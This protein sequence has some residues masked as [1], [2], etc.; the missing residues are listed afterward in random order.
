MKRKIPLLALGFMMSCLP[1]LAQTTTP[2]NEMSLPS[3]VKIPD[4]LMSGDINTIAGNFDGDSNN[5]TVLLGNRPLPVLKESS[6]HVVFKIPNDILGSQKLT[7]IENGRS[8]SY[9]CKVV[10]VELSVDKPHLVKGESATVTLK[11]VGMHN[12]KVP[13]SVT[14]QNLSP[15]NVR[16]QGGAEQMVM[17]Y[18]QDVDVNGTFTKSFKLKARQ[19]GGF[20]IST[21]LLSPP[22]AEWN[23]PNITNTNPYASFESEYE[24]NFEGTPVLS[25]NKT[26]ENNEEKEQSTVPE[27]E[28]QEERNKGREIP[29]DTPLDPRDP[30]DRNKPYSRPVPPG[31]D[32][33]ESEERKYWKDM[34]ALLEDA[35]EQDTIA[36]NYEGPIVP[37]IPGYPSMSTTTPWKTS[38]FFK[39]NVPCREDIYY[40]YQRYDYLD[41]RT[42][43]FEEQ[44]SPSF[45]FF[46]AEGDSKIEFTKTTDHWEYGATAK[47]GKGPLEIEVNGK[48]WTTTIK[49]D[50]KG[51]SKLRGR[52]L[53][54]F[55][56]GR[57]YLVRKAYLSV[58]YEYHYEV[59]ENGTP[60]TWV[61]TS[62]RDH[63]AYWY[64]WEEEIVVAFKDDEGN[65]HRMD[66]FPTTIRTEKQSEKIESYTIDSLDVKNFKDPDVE[67]FFPNS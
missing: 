13:V 50:G 11:F 59:C 47:I 19:S 31:I 48:N 57:L 21:I 51:S 67:D 62:Y 56:I 2:N 25:G 38:Y 64:D 34:D 24:T 54:L 16:L 41:D 33:P 66:A 35:R 14:L 53:W 4:Y 29:E 12:L 5:T 61:V 36:N 20:S 8:L 42:L 58:E 27:A 9:P 22:I 40:F 46:I 55:H 3:I 18:P 45:E 39:G 63:W 30:K 52:H 32:P 1:L 65:F 7:F 37:G 10:G 26:K 28:I 44:L 17:V 60:K 23:V 15:K 6:T 49:I 43:L